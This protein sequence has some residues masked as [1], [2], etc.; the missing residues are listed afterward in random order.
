M[1]KTYPKM[2]ETIKD[3]LKMNEENQVH[4]YAVA[5]IEELEE[6]NKQLRIQLNCYE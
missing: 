4:A 5:R 3:L 1:V 6:E 2:N